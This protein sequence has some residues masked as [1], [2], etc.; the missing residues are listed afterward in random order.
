MSSGEPG[1]VEELYVADNTG[2]DWAGFDASTELLAVAELARGVER[3]VL[4][5]RASGALAAMV[6]FLDSNA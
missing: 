3:A 5:A 1:F 2:S 4:P 6:V